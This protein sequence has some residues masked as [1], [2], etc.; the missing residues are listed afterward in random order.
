M[1]QAN[2]HYTFL[3]DIRTKFWYDIIKTT[4]SKQYMGW[5]AESRVYH[6]EPI[7]FADTH[8]PNKEINTFFLD[9]T[10]D[11]I[12][13]DV[14]QLMD[15]TEYLEA[16]QTRNM[17]QDI[18]GWQRAVTTYSYS[19]TRKFGRIG[20]LLLTYDD[21]HLDLDSE[22]LGIEQMTTETYTV[23]AVIH[24]NHKYYAL[25]PEFITWCL[26]PDKPMRATWFTTLT[27]Q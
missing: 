6:S 27:Y 7:D 13:D 14:K 20:E 9:E 15:V 17:T 1:A 22:Q 12:P 23:P 2:I 16:L 24:F 21:K 18:P 10:F 5:S 4:Y 11:R 8:E 25:T 3:D 26:T 19:F